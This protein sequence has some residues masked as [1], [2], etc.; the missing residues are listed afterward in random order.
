MSLSR[1]RRHRMAAQTPRPPAARRRR[2]QATSCGPRATRCCATCGPPRDDVRQLLVHCLAHHSRRTLA[3]CVCMQ[4]CDMLARHDNQGF[5][6]SPVA[7]HV[8]KCVPWAD[9]F[10]AGAGGWLASWLLESAPAFQ[11]RYSRKQASVGSCCC[12]CWFFTISCLQLSHAQHTSIWMR[13]WGKGQPA[14]AGFLA[15]LATGGAALRQWQQWK[16]QPQRSLQ[17]LLPG[18]SSDVPW[19]SG[20]PTPRCDA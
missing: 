20:T 12:C 16:Q 8:R 13:Q 7:L 4:V 6:Q 10:S 14:L 11:L 1:W 17:E 2:A 19:M 5:V 9:D 3:C 18:A 15:L